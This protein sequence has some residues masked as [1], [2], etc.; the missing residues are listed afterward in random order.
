MIFNFS[1]KF[2]IVIWQHTLLTLFLVNFDRVQME[3]I[4][5]VF[6]TQFSSHSVLTYTL[7]NTSWTIM[8]VNRR[9]NVKSQC[10]VQFNKEIHTG[11]KKFWTIDL[12]ADGGSDNLT[13][14]EPVHSLVLLFTSFC[15]PSLWTTWYKSLNK[16]MNNTC[17]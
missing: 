13:K 12:S 14:T 5:N 3:A 10:E 4:R 17:A 2:C 7:L 9:G 15:F 6:Q 11:F 1:I 16:Y 8:S